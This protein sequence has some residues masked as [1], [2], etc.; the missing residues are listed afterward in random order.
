MNKEEIERMEKVKRIL[1]EE[2]AKEVKIV[3]VN[4]NRREK[5]M[6][7]GCVDIMDKNKYKRILIK[8][9][10]ALNPGEKLISSVREGF[11]VISFAKIEEK[12]MENAIEAETKAGEET[13]SLEKLGIPVL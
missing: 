9:G 8:V 13:F 3:N 1:K 6:I 4:K 5:Q 12:V 7:A 2:G 11:L 10:R